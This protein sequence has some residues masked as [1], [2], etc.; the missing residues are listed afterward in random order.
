MPVLSS[1]APCSCEVDLHNIEDK[2]LLN[3]GSV[4]FKKKK[5]S[6]AL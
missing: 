6:Y 1:S 2:Q 3:V 4:E 5:K